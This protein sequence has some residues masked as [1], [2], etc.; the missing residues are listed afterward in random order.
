MNLKLTHGSLR[1]GEDDLPRPNTNRRG[2]CAAHTIDSYPALCHEGPRGGRICAEPC[3]IAGAG[4]LVPHSPAGQE[5]VAAETSRIL[6]TGPVTSR[7]RLRCEEAVERW[8][9]RT[10][11]KEGGEKRPPEMTDA[12]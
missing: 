8:G 3:R 2:L 1:P 12:G 9:D 6:R 4:R 7:T 10:V 11:Q 5:T